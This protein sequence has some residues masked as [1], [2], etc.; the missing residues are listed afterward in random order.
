[1]AIDVSQSREWLDRLPGG[2]RLSDYETTWLAFD[3]EKRPVITIFGAYDTGKSSLIRRLLLDSGMSV[4]EWLTISARHETFEVNTADLA[5]CVIRDTPGIAEDAIDMR[6]DINSQ[7]ALVAMGLTDIGVVTV[8]PQLATAERAS[9]L[10]ILSQDWTPGS[11]WFVISRFDEAG[12]DPEVNLARY[13]DLAERKRAELRESLG[14]TPESRIF[15]VSQDFAQMAGAASDIDA[16][17][18]DGSRAWDGMNDLLEAITSV[19]EEQNPSYRSSAEQRFWRQAVVHELNGLRSELA[20]S[21]HRASTA[22]IGLNR[23]EVWLGQLDELD[24]GAQA[25]LQGQVGETVRVLVLKQSHDPDEISDEL[26]ASLQLWFE[27]HNHQLDVFLQEI[28]VTVERERRTP[29]W[30]D[31]EELASSITERRPPIG[32]C[33]CLTVD[34]AHRRQDGAQT[35]ES[36]A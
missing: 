21:Q 16:T 1:M 2:S 6:G 14:V 36:A 34:H 26:R 25:D 5:G 24:K 15:V 27:A 12:V 23:R 31:L 18:W 17:I 7:R 28:D 30:Q 22:A 29:A 10:S 9:L 33:V 20:A 19:A 35:A 32:S 4:P 8:T 11:L 13:Q 3:A